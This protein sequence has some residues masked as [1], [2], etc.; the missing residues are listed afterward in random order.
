MLKTQYVPSL[1]HGSDENGNK[2]ISMAAALINIGV[3]T[4]DRALYDAGVKM[5]RGR[6]PALVYLKSDGPAPV[7][8]ASGKPA[9][10]GNKGKTPQFVDGLLQE[11]AR[12]SQHANM[13]FASMVNGAETARQQGLDLYA[14][15][16]ARIRA[17]MEFQ[18]QF[19]KPNAA[20]P[21]PNLAFNLHPTWE[22]AYNHFHDRLGLDLPLMA[23]VIPTNRPTGVNHHMAW[24]TLTHGEVGSVGLPAGK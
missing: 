18:A 16:G 14:E 13:A 3:F 21:P 19:L 10:W 24:E 12:D 4:D 11:T 23:A 15:Q 22:I 9:I 1:I 8:P 20:T 5:W 17:A 7:L 2:E 6:A